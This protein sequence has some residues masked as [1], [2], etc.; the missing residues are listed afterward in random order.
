MIRD[1]VFYIAIKNDSTEFSQNQE[2][3]QFNN[4]PDPPETATIQ[5]RS[6]SSEE[7]KNILQSITITDDSNIV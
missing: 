4:I 6:E 1:K 7:T 5:N 3:S 2:T